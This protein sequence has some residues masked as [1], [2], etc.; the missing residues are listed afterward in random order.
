[1]H[2]PAH[3]IVCSAPL[4]FAALGAPELVTRR[5]ASARSA[6]SYFVRV[7]PQSVAGSCAERAA[8][9]ASGAIADE[10]A[11]SAARRRRVQTA[12]AG[13]S[14]YIPRSSTSDERHR[15]RRSAESTRPCS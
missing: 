7:A 4:A 9:C 13:Q 6:R 5:D 1:F 11:S 2:G 3:L 10:L 15:P 8:T 14:R 12:R